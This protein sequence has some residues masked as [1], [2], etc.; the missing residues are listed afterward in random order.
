MA[1]SAE[2]RG[3]VGYPE[4]ANE[5]E[6][7]QQTV[8]T[9]QYPMSIGELSGMYKEGE[10]VLNPRFQR[11]YR[12]SISQQ[13]ALIESILIGIPVPPIF[14][15]ERKEDSKWEV[16]DGL[17]RVSTIL[18]FMG[19]LKD[20][21]GNLVP[22]IPLTKTQYLPALE[23][24]LWQS[25]AE[26]NERTYSLPTSTQ[27]AF[28]RSKIGIQIIK[29]SSAGSTKYDLFQRLNANGSPLTPQEYRS[30]LLVM[31]SEESF[32]TVTKFAANEPFRNILR[33][34]AEDLEKQVDIDYACRLLTHVNLEYS[35]QDKDLEEFISSSVKTLFVDSPGLV[36]STLQ[37]A[38]A[39]ASALDRIYGADALRKQNLDGRF[40]GRLGKV[41]FEVI[42]VGLTYNWDS[43]SKLPDVENFIRERILR[44][45][46]SPEIEGFSSPGTRG[47]DRIRRTV[48]F[49]KEAFRP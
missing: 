42:L 9:D 40:T 27:I 30:C 1:R 49:G 31:I 11:Y 4:L 34:D 15:Y 29:R 26:D 22:P 12:W 44:V 37:A 23:G 24:A 18:Q 43:V 35:R 19:L 7:A 6:V 17:Q 8:S 16:I 21:D 45:W 20:K 46:A 48:P 32:D 13:S 36:Q 25:E 33:L 28:K 38:T 41:G 5:I 2:W 3:V 14:C 47:T 39:A 10:L